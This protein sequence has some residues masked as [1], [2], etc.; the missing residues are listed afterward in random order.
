M[1]K[2]NRRKF[3]KVAGA[4]TAVV[5]GVSVP[6]AG[7]LAG[8]STKS[9]TLT[10]RAVAGLPAKPLPSYASYV[11]EG[12]VDLASGSGVMTKTVFAGSPEAMSTIALPGMSRIARITSIEDQG[13]SLRIIGTV[14]DRS[15]LQRGE[16]PEFSAFIDRT[17]GIV[18]A[19]FFGKEV[20]LLLEN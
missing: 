14:D 18:R 2:L 6:S 15:Q 9:G 12:H 8:N 4:S 19:D 13:G 5:A 11:L 10:F 7:L 17:S 3:L 20:S 16:S 1:D